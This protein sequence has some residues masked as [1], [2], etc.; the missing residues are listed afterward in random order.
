MSTA[1]KSRQ[2]TDEASEPQDSVVVYVHGVG[3]T[4]SPET[5]KA[6]WDLALFGRDMGDR[7]SM[8]Y[9]ADLVR[10]IGP[11]E[12]P[13]VRSSALRPLDAGAVL[14]DAGVSPQ[15]G[16]AQALA[17]ALLQ[18]LGETAPTAGGVGK[19]ILPL[20]GVIRKPISRAFIQAFIGD[21]AA[22]F[23]KPGMRNKMRARLRARLPKGRAVTLVAHSQGT[24]IAYELLSLLR[25]ADVDLAAFITLGS[26]L[27][28]DEI[29]DFLEPE[30]GMPPPVRM[31]KNFADPLDPVAMDKQLANDFSSARVAIDDEV[32]L[33]THSRRVWGFNPHSAVGYLAHPSVR[34]AVNDAMRLDVLSRFVLARDVAET[35]A[36]P[37][38]QRHPVLIEVLEPGYNALYE[39]ELERQDMEASER[40][41][42]RRTP[43]APLP[44]L[45]LEHRIQ[46]AAQQ[47]A[48]LVDDPDAAVI[49]PLRRFVAARLTA[50]EL[51]LVG[52]AHKEMRVYAVWQSSR[53][54]KFTDR[55]MRVIKADAALNSFSADG[56]G[57]TWAVLDTGIRGDHPHFRTGMPDAVIEAVW[58]CTKRGAPVPVDPAKAKDPDGH[59]TH[60]A[61]IIAGDASN[62]LQAGVKRTE[63]GVAPKTR[64]VIYKVL[65][66]KGEGEDAWII[67]ALDH[68]AQQNE[69]VADG[70]AIHGINLSLGGPFDSTVYGC[71][72]SPICVELR[73]QW[74]AGVMVVV[75]CGNEGQLR[76]Q[77][78][79]GETEINT[80]MSIGDPANLEDCI[81][82]GSVNA[83]KPHLYGIS[84]F[85]SRGPTSDGRGKP[86]VV[87]PGERICSCNSRYRNASDLYYRE[88]GTSM[89]AP[90]VSGLLAAFL[91][92]RREFRGRPDEVKKVLLDTCTDLGR[93]RYHQGRGVPNLMQMLLAV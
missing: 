3:Q 29:Q 90:H 81:A 21:T 68:I 34:R 62:V 24:I 49:D 11:A 53:K 20:P 8:A 82:V 79:G 38:R 19:K 12:G 63:R 93:D 60:V 67:K 50:P 45:K 71:G 57:I 54:A 2:S 39:S 47:L 31:W 40:K 5:L 30:P 72:F 70:L 74:R 10:T 18:R 7:S 41:E 78:P 92:V 33:N 35:L 1:K 88:S 16:Q 65:N 28:L 87:A 42:L 52:M 46:Q 23:F 51:R 86:D 66:D 13:S 37:S 61:G 43:T 22:Y 4:A 76:V 73:R 44:P 91:S 80:A 69:N 59:G 85:S 89:A 75:A 26:P 17:E 84:S 56:A 27:G 6:D 9:W 83:D 14:Q 48:Q 58:D 15:N 77:T 25:E 32:I 36:A 64:L 55:S